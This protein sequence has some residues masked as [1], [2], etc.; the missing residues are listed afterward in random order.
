M[1][2]VSS[3]IRAFGNEPFGTAVYLASARDAME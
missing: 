2:P 3:A 1:F